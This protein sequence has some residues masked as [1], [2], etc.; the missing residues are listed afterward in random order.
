[1]LGRLFTRRARWLGSAVLLA[2]ALAVTWPG[3]A[4]YV[5]TGHVTM[6]WSRAVLGS[7]LVVLFV[8][9]GT[10]TFTL[11]MLELI[12]TQRRPE[13][14]PRPPDRIRPAASRAG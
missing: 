2:A 10:T 5:A 4:Q 3:L 9:L 8:A 6:H 11:N 1:V 14:R 12:E 7:L 13:D